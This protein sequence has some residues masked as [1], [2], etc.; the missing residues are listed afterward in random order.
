MQL[1]G[2]CNS[3]VNPEAQIVCAFKACQ[4]QVNLSKLITNDRTPVAII[5]GWGGSSHKNVSKYANIYHKS[6]CITVQYIL[7]TR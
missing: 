3:K 4:L 2:K 6:G 5:F 7:A 1:K